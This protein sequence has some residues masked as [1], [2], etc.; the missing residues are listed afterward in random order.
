[1]FYDDAET[2]A[3]FVDAI[4]ET[5]PDGKPVFLME[6]SDDLLTDVPGGTVRSAVDEK[7]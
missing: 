7:A 5:A 2:R 6:I 4:A 3:K 1:M